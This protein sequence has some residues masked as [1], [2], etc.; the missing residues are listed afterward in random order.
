M[1]VKMTPTRSILNVSGSGADSYRTIG[2]AVAAAG[3]GDVVSIQPGTYT[4]S[5]VLDR[6]VTLSA[7][8]QG[9]VRIISRG[10]PAIRITGDA[11]TLS[12]IVIQHVG[13][14]TSAIDVPTGRLRMEE[15]RVQAES[16]VALYAYGAVEI[17]ARNCDFT[18]PG[19]AGLIFVD[20]AEGD[21]IQCKVHHV[22]A[23]AV[24]IRTGAGPRLVDCA[25]EDVDGSGLLVAEEA[26]G[27]VRNCRI[28]RAG[29]PAVAIEGGSSPEMSGTVIEEASGV[30][31]VIASGSTPLLE[32]CAVSNAE[33]QGV[34]L[35]EGAAPDIRRLEVEGAVGYGLHVLGASAGTFVECRVTGAGGDSVLVAEKATTWFEA[36]RVEA[37]SGAGV[38]VGDSATPTFDEL[39]VEGSGG[40]GLEVWSSANPRVRRAT[41]SSPA[42]N[43]VLVTALGRGF[44]EETTVTGPRGMGLTVTEGGS[45]KL[46]GFAISRP[47]GAAVSVVGGEADLEGGEISDSQAHGVLAGEGG[48]VRLAR[49]RVRGSRRAGIEWGAGSSGSMAECEVTAGGGDGILVQ[50][51]G[52]VTLRDCLVRD[53]AGAGVRVTTESPQ[54]EISGVTSRGNSAADNVVGL[55]ADGANLDLEKAD[56]HVRDSGDGVRRH[57]P[58]VPSNGTTPARGTGRAHSPRRAD[59]GARQGPLGELLTELDRLVGLAEVKREV[60]TLV[61]L[62][63]MAARRAAVGL[64]PPPQSRHLVFTGSP[65]TGKT[66]VARLYGRVLAELGVIATGQLVEVGRPDLVASIVGGTALKTTERFEQARGGVLFI[67]EAYT[68]AANATGGPDFGREAIDTL[69]KLME[70]HRDEVVVIVAG[71]T[72]EM[73]KF[74][75]MNPGL[76]SRFS[77]TIEFADYS[78]GDLV[79]IVENQCRAYDY[80][81]EFETRA[82]LATYFE[83]MARDEAFGNGRTARKVFEEMVGRQAYRLA[84][85]PDVTPVEMTRLLPS[86]L[87]PPPAAGVGAG[88]GADD[89]ERVEA[90]LA[91]L[92]QMVGLDDV[93]HEVGSIVDLLASSRQRVAAGLPAPP[94]S[95]HLIF[96]GPPGTGKTTVARLYG[97]IL[98]ALGVLARGQVIEVGRAELVGEYVGHTAQRT[99]AAFD[100]ARGGVLFI[101][102]AYTLATN[103]TGGPDFGRE[104]IDTLVKLMEDHRDEVVVIAAGY[105]QEMGAFLSTNP[106]LSSRFPRWVRFASYSTDEL[107]TIVSQ[108]ASSAGYELSGAT[109]TALRTHFAAVSRGPS[110]GNG[111]YAR[112]VLNEAVTRHAQR[113]RSLKSPTVQDLSLILPED[114]VTAPLASSEDT[115]PETEA[116]DGR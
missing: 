82:E 51:T 55:S 64:P 106:G 11:A 93:K 3:Y 56:G 105:Q 104:A 80:R 66:T 5:V 39:H 54:L 102:E 114:V 88:A 92:G 4:E 94:L 99:K 112:Q 22:R 79:T 18:N 101:D 91:E 107:V 70:D 21:L 25:I 58:T 96:G 46:H 17:A 40:N 41:I 84:T 103:A 13:E 1:A 36:L 98:A 90:L 50:S 16:A 19:G 48:S 61:R 45:P 26:R 9:E 108:H 97:S 73:R 71:Y 87:G 85:E 6:E 89:S 52:Q 77:R 37:G 75:A 49:M 47:S 110:F 78:S 109:V 67:D 76:A 100:R 23:S 44:F 69:V 95:R 81:L 68:L 59:D 86:D 28:V 12:G 35:M 72:H 14:Q 62:H 83:N 30:G 24:V 42:G 63:Q 29:N 20:G 38:S 15:C 111:R 116:R 113:M 43:G 115:Q 8:G 7:A 10:D 34:V 2:D 53:N 32:D 65:G 57:T 31:V 74:L 60:E 33:A 27:T